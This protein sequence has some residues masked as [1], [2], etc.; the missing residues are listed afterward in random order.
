MKIL[1]DNFLEV[2]RNE[3]VVSIVSMNETEPHIANTW[4]SFVQISEEGNIL[5]PAAGMQATEKNVGLN[6]KIKIALGSKEVMG[7]NNYQG[8]GFLIE[9]TASFI[10][11]GANFNFMKEKFPFISR[12]LELEINS[13][14][15]KI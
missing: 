14:Q 8:C 15:Q 7:F 6:N 11:S 5:I 9:G 13:I 4:N 10:N 3:G 2:L 12:V 1:E